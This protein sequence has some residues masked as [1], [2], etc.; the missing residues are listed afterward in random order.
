MLRCVGKVVGLCVFI[1]IACWLVGYPSGVVTKSAEFI[2]SNLPYLAPQRILQAAALANIL[3]GCLLQKSSNLSGILI[4]L[5]LAL[6]I[7]LL[8]NPS[9]P[10]LDYQQKVSAT[11]SFYKLVSMAGA[12]L[13]LKG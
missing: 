5:V 9:L 11:Y 7:L 12:M 3:A 13:T 2:H 4:I 1:S 10:G 8:G 6:D